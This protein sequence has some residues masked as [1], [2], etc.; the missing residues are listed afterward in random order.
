MTEETDGRLFSI[1]GN[2]DFFSRVVVLSALYS[3]TQRC[4]KVFDV[5]HDRSIISV[6]DGIDGNQVF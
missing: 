5:I 1:S 2:Q 6:C 3:E 4:E